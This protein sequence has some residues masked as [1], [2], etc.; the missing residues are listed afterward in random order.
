MMME[1]SSTVPGRCPIAASAT[2]A[3]YRE[4]ARLV[5]ITHPA[6]HGAIAAMPGVEHGAQVLT[7]RARVPPRVFFSAR[8]DYQ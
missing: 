2:G 3:P 4:L 6:D 5:I 7:I 8:F 1:R